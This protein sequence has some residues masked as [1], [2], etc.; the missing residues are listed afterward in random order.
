MARTRPLTAAWHEFEDQLDAMP[1]DMDAGLREMLR[2]T[3]FAGATMIAYQFIDAAKQADR[4]TAAVY[5]D[6]L[7]AEVQGVVD[8]TQRLAAVVR[9]AGKN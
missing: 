8:V 3:F 9:A 2:R 5:I 1:V 4:E 7:M 6:D